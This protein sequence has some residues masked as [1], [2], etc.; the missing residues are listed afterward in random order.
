MFKKYNRSDQS[1]DIDYIVKEI[2]INSIVQVDNKITKIDDMPMKQSSQLE[3]KIMVLVLLIIL[4]VCMG[5]HSIFQEN[6][7]DVWLKI[8]QTI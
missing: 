1:P 3:Y 8:L 2:I 7:L 4:L 6:I 5:E